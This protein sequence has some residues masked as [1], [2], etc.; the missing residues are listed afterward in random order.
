VQ[1]LGLTAAGGPQG[2]SGMLV[3]ASERLLVVSMNN[4]H[5]D[6][7]RLRDTKSVVVRT[8]NQGSLSTPEALP[9]SVE[10]F[11]F[12]WSA[13]FDSLSEA[14]HAVTELSWT[15]LLNC[16]PCYSSIIEISR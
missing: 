14:V 11:Q 13:F 4:K 12:A 10:F 15:T 9:T 1:L 16:S 6:L 5:G 3:G 2:T 7:M 8:R